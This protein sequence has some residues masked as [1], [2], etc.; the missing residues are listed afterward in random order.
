M[1][2]RFKAPKKSDLKQWEKVA[3]LAAHGFFFQKVYQ[4]QGCLWC[5]VNYPRTLEDAKA[6]VKEYSD[7]AL[8]VPT[9]DGG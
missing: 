1:D 9:Q 8:P 4:K 2:T 6:F 5:R 3:F 7:Q